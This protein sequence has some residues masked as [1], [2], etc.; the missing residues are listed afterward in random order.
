MK[1]VNEVYGMNEGEFMKGGK[2]VEGVRGKVIEW[3]KG[4]REWREEREVE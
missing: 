1:E 4:N 3:E 2:I